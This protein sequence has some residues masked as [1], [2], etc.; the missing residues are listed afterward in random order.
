MSVE[1]Q[2]FPLSSHNERLVVY[3][4]SY[5]LRG[6]RETKLGR[7]VMLC[8]EGIINHCSYRAT[9]VRRSNCKLLQGSFLTARTIPIPPPFCAYT[10]EYNNLATRMGGHRE[11][12]LGDPAG[13]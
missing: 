4:A 12:N 1:E 13:G 10:Q 9:K 3:V 11:T 5:L 8:T 7:L 6:H 2:R